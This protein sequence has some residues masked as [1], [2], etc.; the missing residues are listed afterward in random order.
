M[1]EQAKPGAAASPGVRQEDSKAEAP[2]KT[3]SEKELPDKDLEKV[4][5]GIIRRNPR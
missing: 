3:A 1:S 5:G 4:S 2:P